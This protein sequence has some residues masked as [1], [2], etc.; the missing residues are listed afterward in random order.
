MSLDIDNSTLTDSVFEN[1]II[2][3]RGLGPVEI[4]RVTFINCSFL[5]VLAGPPPE[6][7]RNLVMTVL[8]S[9]GSK[10]TF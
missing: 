7:D 8:G 3:Y 10:I 9:K 4:K 6:S 2:R 1:L 5:M